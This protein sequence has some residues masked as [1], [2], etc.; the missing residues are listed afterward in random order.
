M[1]ESATTTLD[2]PGSALRSSDLVQ[3][4]WRPAQLPHTKWTRSRGLDS[5]IVGYQPGG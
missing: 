5:R 1:R 4:S 3:P 2:Q